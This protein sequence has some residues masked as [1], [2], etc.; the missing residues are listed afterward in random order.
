MKFEPARRV[1][2]GIVGAGHMGRLH[3]QKAVA[4]AGEDASLAFVGVADI[5]PERAVRSAAD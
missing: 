5:E 2:L 3:A 4:I 1:R